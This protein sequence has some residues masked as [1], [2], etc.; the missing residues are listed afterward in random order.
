MLLFNFITHT[1]RCHLLVVGGGI[2]QAKSMQFYH[3]LP[4]STM[5]DHG[6][7]PM[8][9]HVM[10]IGTTVYEHGQPWSTTS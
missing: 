10:V 9:D 6:P 3:E 1:A 7:E 4:W 8:V 2:A 5:V